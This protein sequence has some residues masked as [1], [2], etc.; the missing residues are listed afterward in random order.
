[1]YMESCVADS[2]GICMEAPT[3]EP[4][5]A[6]IDTDHI[7]AGA[8]RLD[9]DTWA[10]DVGAEFSATLYANTI[11]RMTSGPLTV[12]EHQALFALSSQ[13]SLRADSEGAPSTITEAR[14]WGEP[15]PSAADKEMGNHA[16]N[17]SWSRVTKSDIP[18]GRRIHK[19]VWVFKLKRDGSAKARLC[20]QGCTME[21]GIDF[22]QTFSDALKY[23]SARGLFALAARLGCQCRS[24]D[25][26]SA[27]LQGEFL[28]GEVVYCYMPPGYEEFTKSGDK[29]YCR[30]DKPIYGIP[31]AGRRLQRCIFPWLAKQGL[32]QLDDSDGCV[33]VHDGSSETFVIG[34]YVD[35]LQIVHS[36]KLDG[37]GKAIDGKSFYA[38]FTRELEKDWDVLDEGPAT[39]LL[40]IEVVYNDDKSITLNQPK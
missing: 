37:N 32:R 9:D 17:A 40:G 36:A 23:E 13:L 8:V 10:S 18:K 38:K 33:W 27:Y 21:H 5:G 20:V 35:N 31:Q 6:W 1:M 11:T 29:L 12:V 3:T 4:L 2:L 15:W 30:V 19:L 16:A 22:D 25:W 26:V 34:I 7:P 39:D 28:D 14:D 24:Y